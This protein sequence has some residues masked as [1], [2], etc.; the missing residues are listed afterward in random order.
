[1]RK[2]E[3]KVYI[4][5]HF[6][7]DIQHRIQQSKIS[8]NNGFATSDQ[9]EQHAR[10]CSLNIRTERTSY[11]KTIT[12]RNCPKRENNAVAVQTSRIMQNHST[13]D[14]RLKRHSQA[15]S[16]VIVTVALDQFHAGC[17]MRLAMTSAKA[18]ARSA[19][20]VL[21]LDAV[22]TESA[23]YNRGFEVG[24]WSGL[25]KSRRGSHGR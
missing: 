4:S 6:L 3:E 20:N 7:F 11:K 15:I 18:K 1:M 2:E 16:A 10:P 5:M 24:R 21:T 13:I 23:K 8:E 12:K 22:D 25:A 17:T 9:G 19:R 14:K